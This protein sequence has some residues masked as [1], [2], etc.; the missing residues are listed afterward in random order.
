LEPEQKLNQILFS[1]AEA[2]AASKND[3]ALQHNT[4]LG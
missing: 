3:A 4:V 2:G 1:K